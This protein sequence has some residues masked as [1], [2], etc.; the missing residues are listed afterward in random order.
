[1]S[2]LTVKL[3]GSTKLCSKLGFDPSCVEVVSTQWKILLEYAEGL[4]NLGYISFDEVRINP[5]FYCQVET[6]DVAIV[7]ILIK[8]HPTIHEEYSSLPKS[9]KNRALFGMLCNAASRY[10]ASSAQDKLKVLKYSKN[11][12]KIE[13]SLPA[14]EIP[15]D[16]AASTTE[17]PAAAVLSNIENGTV[18]QNDDSDSILDIQEGSE[19]FNRLFGDLEDLDDDDDIE[20]LNSDQQI[21][22]Y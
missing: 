18:A 3:K 19:K 1:M 12:E 22:N 14:M 17:A 8:K 10:K 2:V 4:F 7:R 21:G 16:V 9:D 6:E 15:K 20:L 5:E 13:M 11:V